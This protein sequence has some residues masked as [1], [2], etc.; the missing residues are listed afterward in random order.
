MKNN[1]IIAVLLVLVLIFVVL[2]N[3]FPFG[4]NNSENF[5]NKAVRAYK[6]EGYQNMRNV[7]P[8]TGPSMPARPMP[9]P[10]MPMPSMPGMPS[11]PT[12]PMPNMPYMPP[13]V[14]PPQMPGPMINTSPQ[15]MPNTPASTLAT[16]QPMLTLDPSGNIVPSSQTSGSQGSTF[17]QAKEGFTN[18]ASSS[19][20]ATNSYEPIGAFDGVALPTGNK[21]SAW[22]YT[23][24][25][26]PLMGAEF[27]P[28]DDSLFMFKNNQCKPECCGASFSCSGGCV[29]TTPKQR[30]YLA[31]RGGNRT[32]PEDSA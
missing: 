3:V 30:D 24:P 20:G 16:P 29:C 6:K 11:M 31:S 4:A 22:R 27:T 12:P 23:A 19:N 1:T 13:Q 21:T 32:K 10:P 14:Q 17:Q 15:N 5:Q 7:N 28:G 26:E 8:P 9:T 2:I 25:N 18:L